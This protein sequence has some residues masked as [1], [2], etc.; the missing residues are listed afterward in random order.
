[1]ET[2]YRSLLPPKAKIFGYT[3]TP[4]SYGHLA[5]LHALNCP[6]LNSN[7]IITSYD[8]VVALRACTLKF[9]DFENF[10]LTKKDYFKAAYLSKRSREVLLKHCL[11][12][13]KYL[14]EH[15]RVPHF[16]DSGEGGWKDVSSPKEL[17]TIAVLVKN[18]IDHNTA[19]DMSIGYANWL[20]ATFSE[21]KGNPRSFIDPL[22]IEAIENDLPDFNKMS[23]EDLYKIVL[24]E[25]GKEKADI[26]L[27]ARKASK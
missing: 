10:K 8:L 7:E 20:A 3:L 12:F 2:F 21:I 9:A 15:Q 16:V 18:G 26:W 25:R 11:H 14:S 4:F 19:W 24:E 13:T 23:D 17:S 22:E 6:F 27:K 1:V 5:L